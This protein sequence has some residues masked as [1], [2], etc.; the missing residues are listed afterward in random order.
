GGGG[1][2]GGGGGRARGEAAAA[3]R[4][5]GVGGR[6]VVGGGSA[7]RA[8]AAQPVRGSAA[9]ESG[10]AARAAGFAGVPGP[11]GGTHRQAGRPHG[12]VSRRPSPKR[13]RGGSAV[14]RWRFRLVSQPH[15]PEAPAKDR[16]LSLAYASGSDAV[17]NLVFRHQVVRLGALHAQR[18]LLQ[19][20]DDVRRHA[21]RQPDVRA[22]HRVV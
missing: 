5:G 4:A 13:K 6:S 9:A 18:R 3:A 8:G 10:I 12:R 15:K 2:G 11:R 22:D 19:R 7:E 21:L 16:L 14:L 1:G 20:D 17:L